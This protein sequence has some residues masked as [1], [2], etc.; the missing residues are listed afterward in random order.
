MLN[1]KAA[2]TL[3][4]S[5][6]TTV[7]LLQSYFCLNCACLARSFLRT[8]VTKYPWPSESSSLLHTFKKEIQYPNKKSLNFKILEFQGIIK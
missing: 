8:H 2:T 3:L 4:T 6:M 7:N 1:M 5:T